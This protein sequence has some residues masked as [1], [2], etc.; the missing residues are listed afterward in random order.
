MQEAIIHNMLATISEHRLN[1]MRSNVALTYDSDEM[2]LSHMIAT[3]LPAGYEEAIL[4][5]D[6]QWEKDRNEYEELIQTMKNFIENT[7]FSS[8][9]SLEDLFKMVGN[10]VENPQLSSEEEDWNE[11]ENCNEKENYNEKDSAEEHDENEEES[12]EDDEN[13]AE[14]E[15]E[16]HGNEEESE[17]CGNGKGEVGQS[18]ES[19]EC[20]NGNG[21]LSESEEDDDGNEKETGNDKD[22][23]SQSAEEVGNR[24]L[25]GSF[26]EIE[27]MNTLYLKDLKRFCRIKKLSQSG[28]K[29]H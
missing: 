2:L 21:Q 14:G 13:E 23:V 27:L 5:L 24:T 7:S 6:A 12:E 17:K 29:L 26:E 18:V 9:S 1:Q 16:D 3:R 15:E 4:A 25:Q 19:E 20:G 8:S 22:E 28:T 10:I 11:K